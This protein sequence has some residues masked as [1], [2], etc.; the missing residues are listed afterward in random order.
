VKITPHQRALGFALLSGLLG[1]HFVV[2]YLQHLPLGAP[3]SD[4]DQL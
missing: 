3:G 4:I 1:L 2:R